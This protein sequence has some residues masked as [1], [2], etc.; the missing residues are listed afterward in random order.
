MANFEPEDDFDKTTFRIE[1]IATSARAGD[2]KAWREMSKEFVRLYA[3]VDQKNTALRERQNA[4]LSEMAELR[5]HS[6][7]LSALATYCQV[8]GLILVMLA[9]IVGLKR[10]EFCLS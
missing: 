2:M 3:L 8:F 10:I 6:A 4:I 9:T 1:N 5:N 7:E